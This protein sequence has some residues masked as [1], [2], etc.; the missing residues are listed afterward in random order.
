MTVE[1]LLAAL[2]GMAIDNC[3]IHCEGAADIVEIPILDGSSQ[4]WVDAFLANGIKEQ[5]AE[6]R[7]LS[8]NV[9]QELNLDDKKVYAKS[10]AG[11]KIEITCSFS[12]P[13]MDR[14]QAGFVITPDCFANEIA[15][16]RTFCMEQDIEDMRQAG[17]IK[18]GG[19]DCA[20][21]FN[22]QGQPVNAEGLRFADEP[23]RH[24]L[25]DVIGDF[26]IFG[27]P[28][29]GHFMIQNPGHGVNNQIMRALFTLSYS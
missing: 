25:L 18:G 16:A 20:V 17:L 7:F 8:V 6:R 15:P 21:V 14:M 5:S 19:L 1:H 9:P 24:K 29:Q 23:I 26:F 27:Q 2:H 4:T 12:V 3:I 10:Y 28:V 22:D 13:G 11:L